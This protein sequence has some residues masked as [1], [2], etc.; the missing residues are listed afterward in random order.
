MEPG[1]VLTFDRYRLDLVNSQLWRGK[2]ALGL[3]SQTF[4][5]LR[6]LVEHAGQV[7]SKDLI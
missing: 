2:R 5:V 1:R 7:V 4:A 3:T 6:Y